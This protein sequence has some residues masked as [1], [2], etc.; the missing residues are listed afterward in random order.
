[1]IWFGITDLSYWPGGLYLEG[2]TPAQDR[3]KPAAKAFRFPFFAQ[4]T[5]RGVRV[6]GLAHGLGRVR[7]RIERGSR[8]RWQPVTVLRSDPRGMIY[9]TVKA[10]PGTFRAKVVSGSGPRL[11]SYPHPAG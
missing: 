11:T 3:P 5:R 10:R 2:P 6:W 1:M 9:T 8:G 7:I 4:A